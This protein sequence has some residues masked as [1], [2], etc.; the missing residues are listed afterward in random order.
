MADLRPLLCACQRKPQTPEVGNPFSSDPQ[1]R[2]V[3][4]HKLLTHAE[5]LE[6]AAENATPEAARRMRAMAARERR[7][8]KESMVE[9]VPARV[10]VRDGA[11]G[12]PRKTSPSSI[13]TFDLADDQTPQTPEKATTDAVPSE[14]QPVTKPWSIVIEGIHSLIGCKAPA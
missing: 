12:V 1:T 10:K 8:S 4:T 13:D 5:K 9:N 6:K 3:E 11:A 14:A 7:R 2:R